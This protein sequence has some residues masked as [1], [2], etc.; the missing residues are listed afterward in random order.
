MK[1][2]KKPPLRLIRPLS[3]NMF[4]AA[5]AILLWP[6]SA[7]ALDFSLLPNPVEDSSYL[8]TTTAEV[9]LGQLLFW[10]KILSGNKSISCGTCHH[11]RFGSSD[12]VS[13]GFGDGGIGVGP[14]RVAD[15]KNYP[16]QRVPRNSPSLYNTGALE[17]TALFADGRIEVDRLRPAGIRSPLEEDMMSGFASILS[18]QTMFPVLSPDEMAGHYEENGIS[19]L[20]RQGRLTGPTGA[21]AEIA[22]RITDLPS[23]QAMFAAAYPKIKAGR[24]LDFTDISNAIA[25]FMT[26]EFRSDTAPFDDFLRGKAPL[27]PAAMRGLEFFYGEGK[28]STCHAGPFMTD[29]DFHPIGTPQLGPGKGERFE[30]HQLDIGR[31]RV[32][33]KPKD[34]FAFRTPSLRNV[35]LTAPYGHAGGHLSLADFLEFHANPK[36]MLAAYKPQGILPKLEGSKDDWAALKNGKDFPKIV[37]AVTSVPVIMTT[38]IRDDL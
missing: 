34:R 15:P 29:H 18:A 7:I 30:H 9:E 38:E 23:Y 37:A 35:T 22:K 27:S 19:T 6:L 26:V 10:D 5:F 20:V 31:M 2:L 3:A 32:T 17:Y 12:G 21:W 36:E 25:A 24:P 33:N 8:P 1:F 11:P 13:L 14:N 28:C 16:E 4:S